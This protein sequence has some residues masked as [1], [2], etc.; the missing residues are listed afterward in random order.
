MSEKLLDFILCNDLDISNGNSCSK[1]YLQPNE[2]CLT[3]SLP[4]LSY[5]FWYIL[6][7]H[8]LNHAAPNGMEE[9]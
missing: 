1:L 7:E 5:Y 8:M 2:Y 3:N 4:W 6:Y 9:N